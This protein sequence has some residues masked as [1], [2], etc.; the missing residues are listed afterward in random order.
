MS[1][2]TKTD[3]DEISNINSKLFEVYSQFRLTI[4]EVHEKT[5][6]LVTTSLNAESE[7]IKKLYKNIQVLNDNFSNLIEDQCKIHFL[8]H[9]MIFII[10]VSEV[11]Q[12]FYD[13]KQSLQRPKNLNFKKNFAPKIYNARITRT[14]KNLLSE[15]EISEYSPQETDSDNYSSRKR[16]QYHIAQVLERQK[17]ID[18][19]S[20][21]HCNFGN[22]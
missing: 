13:L 21:Y 9:S 15:S 2:D 4:T 20:Y 14:K 19:V 17:A 10:L 11:T 6:K 18:M 1:N 5:Q 12:S 7:F 22:R 16:G 8:F 3:F